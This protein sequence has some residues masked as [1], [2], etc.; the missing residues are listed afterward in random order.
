[1]HYLLFYSYVENMVERRDPFRPEHL[2]LARA[3]NAN[4]KLKMA[5]AYADPVDGGLFIFTSREAV[6]EFV[7]RDPYMANGLVTSHS[8][9]EWNVVVGG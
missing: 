7:A 2:D 1:M 6:D 9:R 4:Q 5:G 3:F 8:V